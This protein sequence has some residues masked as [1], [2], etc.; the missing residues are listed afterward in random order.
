MLVLSRKI[1]K[2]IMIGDNV[3]IV[4]VGIK[5]DQVRLGINAPRHIAV[6]RK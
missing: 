1:N 6:Y 3:E 5:D 4:V 2:R